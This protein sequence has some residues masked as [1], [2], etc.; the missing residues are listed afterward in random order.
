MERTEHPGRGILSAV[1]HT[2]ANDEAYFLNYGESLKKDHTPGKRYIKME[3]RKIYE[4]ALSKVPEAM[5]ACLDKAGIGISEV[6]KVFIHQANEKMDEGIIRRF[7]GLYDIK[8]LPE[9]IMPMS[10]HL[11]GNSSVATVPTLLDMVLKGDLPEH[12]VKEGDVVLLASVGAGMNIS[13][14]T[15]R[16]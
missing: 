5:K 8:Q 13:A 15:Y 4:F 14:I 11:L 10:I 12:D 7:Y 9:R 6:K 16:M 3:G 2:Y 1:T